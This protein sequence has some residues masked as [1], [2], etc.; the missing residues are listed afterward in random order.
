MLKNSKEEKN[1]PTWKKG[2]VI[3]ACGKLALS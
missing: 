1:M 2:E 3:A